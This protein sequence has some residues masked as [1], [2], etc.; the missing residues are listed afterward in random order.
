MADVITASTSEMLW[1]FKSTSIDCEVLVVLLCLWIE[2]TCKSDKTIAFL[3]P[4]L[5]Y[6]FIKILLQSVLVYLYYN[7]TNYPV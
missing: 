5:K 6:S 7:S 4:K 2:N 3:K 1:L